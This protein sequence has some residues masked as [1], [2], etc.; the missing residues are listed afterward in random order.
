MNVVIRT[1]V[2]VSTLAPAIARVV[3]DVDPTVPVAKLREMDGVFA[4]SIRRPRLLA[5]LLALFSGLALLLAAI[6]TYGVL[7]Y[8]VGERRHE[9]GIRLALG[10][11]RVRVLRHVM[12]QGLI[13]AAIGVAI[14]LTGVLVLS[15]LLTSLLFGVE[16]GDVTT[17]AIAVESIIGI[18][19]LASWFPAWRASRL[20]PN[21]ILRAE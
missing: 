1:T 12:M 18:A 4:E 6:G 9:I 14:G 21:A 10:A 5:Q 7:A 19:A 2:P 3:H 20:D 17:M 15:R 13:P 8:S 11:T 16:P